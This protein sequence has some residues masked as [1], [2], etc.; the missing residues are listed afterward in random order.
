MGSYF[1]LIAVLMFGNERVDTIFSGTITA[2]P[3]SEVKVIYDTIYVS[4]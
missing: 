4:E 1:K 3:L 2:K